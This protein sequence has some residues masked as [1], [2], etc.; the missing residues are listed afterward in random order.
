[1]YK[2][3][4]FLR[5]ANQ[6]KEYGYQEVNL[7]LGC[8]SKTVVT[9]GCGAGFLTDVYKRQAAWNDGKE[10][11]VPKVVGQDMVFYKLTDFAQLE[12]GYFGI[13][14]PARGEIVQWEE[15]LMIMPGVAFDRQNHRVGYG[16]G[17]Y[18][19]FLEKHPY[20]TRVA[21][22]F[23]FQMMSEV[24]VEPTDISPEIIVTEK[25]MCIR[26][27]NTGDLSVEE[28]VRIVCQQECERY[29]STWACP[30]AVGTLKECEERIRKFGQAVFFSSVAEVS[31]LMLSLIHI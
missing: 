20:I 2:R 22:A 12:K 10:V 23:E 1:M 15:A 7:N 28:R 24:P 11:A 17:F 25:E 30:P 3:Q 29:G 19:R 26:D 18:D 4:D 9:K 5:T 8:P 21:V 13:P 27:R 14:E 6:L 16:G 31:D